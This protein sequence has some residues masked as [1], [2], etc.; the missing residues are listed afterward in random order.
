MSPKQMASELHPSR[1]PAAETATAADGKFLQ[2]LVDATKAKAP[3]FA[4]LGFTEANW[5]ELR[6]QMLLQLPTLPAASSQTNAGGGVNYAVEMKITG[7]KG[8]DVLR[9]VW[10]HSP[11][12][13]T[14]H[15]VTAYPLREK[16]RQE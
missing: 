14:T 11:T 2:Y 12:T 16:S 6:D 7:P 10:S 15:L 8:S 4:A 13:S 1:V 9:T 3:V 5:T